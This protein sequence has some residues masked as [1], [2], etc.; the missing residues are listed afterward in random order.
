MA[1]TGTSEPDRAQFMCTGYLDDTMQFS[2]GTGSAM[3]K[4]HQTL[5]A[6]TQGC[7]GVIRDIHIDI[8]VECKAFSKA[9]EKFKPSNE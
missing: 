2:A 4:L 6:I 3:P 7:R 5:E 1:E 9:G 8:A